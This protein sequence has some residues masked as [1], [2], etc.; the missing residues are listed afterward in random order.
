MDSDFFFAHKI[1]KWL[2]LPEYS[3]GHDGHVLL[4]KNF[5]D[6][7]KNLEQAHKL[8]ETKGKSDTP[9]HLSPNDADKRGKNYPLPGLKLTEDEIDFIISLRRINASENTPLSTATLNGLL[10][11]IDLTGIDSDI[12][13][14]F[15]RA[16]KSLRRSRGKNPSDKE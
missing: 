1:E 12:Q 7:V 6:I 3:V 2:K 5:E 8:P 13:S 9:P 4:T 10:E 14:S 15:V 11:Y 16:I